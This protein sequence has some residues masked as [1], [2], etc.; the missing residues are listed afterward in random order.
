VKKFKRWLVNRI[1][2]FILKHYKKDF[3][4][5]VYWAIEQQCHTIKHYIDY[6]AEN[7]VHIQLQLDPSALP[8]GMTLEYLDEDEDDPT[9]PDL[10]IV[11]E[12][13]Q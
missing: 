2:P 8:F 5:Y 1:S 7:G 3:E 11:P 13:E 4:N 10:R 12:D 6:A 9:R